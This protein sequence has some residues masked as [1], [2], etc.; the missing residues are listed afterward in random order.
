MKNIFRTLESSFSKKG[1]QLNQVTTAVFLP[2][3]LILGNAHT[4]FQVRLETTTPLK[5]INFCTLPKT[6]KLIS[7]QISEKQN[8][9][10]RASFC[11]FVEETFISQS[12]PVYSCF[13]T[14]RDLHEVLVDSKC[15]YKIQ[16][17]I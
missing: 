14:C 8:Q 4:N 12:S 2:P 11:L 16:F 5:V 6:K 13:K 15:M 17:F 1:R 9:V 10:K 3:F 7:D